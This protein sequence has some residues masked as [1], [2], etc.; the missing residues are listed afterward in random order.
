MKRKTIILSL[1]GAT[2]LAGLG[3]TTVV[4]RGGEWCDNP[5]IARKAEARLDRLETALKLQPGQQAAWGTF[6]TQLKAEA[7]AVETAV[8]DWR[9]DAMPGTA[10]GR[11]EHMQV[12]LDRGQALLS[13]LAQ[14]TQTF[15]P[16][17][18][19]EQQ[20]VFDNEFRFGRHHRR[21][22]WHE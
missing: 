15:Y 16:T 9:G 13:T 10:L 21:G 11:L 12:G 19:A 17:L 7:K 1:V 8:H 5:P 20:A 18:D 2:A 14:A 6:E 4:A 3:A 22:G